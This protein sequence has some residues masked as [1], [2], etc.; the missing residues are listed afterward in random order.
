MGEGGESQPGQTAEEGNACGPARKGGDPPD[1]LAQFAKQH[2]KSVWHCWERSAL[3]LKTLLENRRIL[4]FSRGGRGRKRRKLLT[5][6]LPSSLPLRCFHFIFHSQECTFN[7]GQPKGMEL[8]CCL[9]LPK[10]SL[11]VGINTHTIEIR[12]C[13]FHIF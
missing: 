7:K 2:M 6:S 13:F 1:I 11:L 9:K 10:G 8:S 12:T 5:L 3:F 4:S